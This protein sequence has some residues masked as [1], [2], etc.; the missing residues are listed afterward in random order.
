MKRQTRSRARIATAPLPLLALVLLAPVGAARA[1]NVAPQDTSIDPQ[2]FQPAIGPHNFL[3]VEG[4]EVPEHK[5]LSFGLTFDYQQQPYTIF[6]EG[7][8][9]GA[10]HL[11]DKQ[12]TGGLAAA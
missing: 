4:A 10:P 9:P 8:N 7:A 2:L 1:Q 3:T 5:R 12:L 6:T 11:I